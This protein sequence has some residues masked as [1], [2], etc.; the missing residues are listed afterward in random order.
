MDWFSDPYMA[1]DGHAD[2]QP[3]RQR[4]DGSW[5]CG[6]DQK[7]LS[8][9]QDSVKMVRWRKP[10]GWSKTWDGDPARVDK[11]KIRTSDV[12]KVRNFVWRW[13]QGED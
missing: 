9:F 11:F 10:D 2:G 3:I 6:Y 13:T 12:P 4:A 7:P 5:T 8:A 1:T